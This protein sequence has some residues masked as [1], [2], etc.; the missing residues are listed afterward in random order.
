MCLYYL[1][2][3]YPNQCTVRVSEE[4]KRLNRE[5]QVQSVELLTKLLSHLISLLHSS[6]KH[7]PSYID[8]IM[9][10]NKVSPYQG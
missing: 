4:N 6:D 5:V 1:R 2:S 8:D 3:F 7:L 9:R 10:K